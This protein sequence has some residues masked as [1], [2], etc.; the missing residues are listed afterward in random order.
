MLREK[1]V[2]LMRNVNV[3]ICPVR[4]FGS[5]AQAIF[6]SGVVITRDVQSQMQGK[7]LR[8]AHKIKKQHEIQVN[9]KPE[10]IRMNFIRNLSPTNGTTFSS[11]S[12]GGTTTKTKPIC[13]LLSTEPALSPNNEVA[14]FGLG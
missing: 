7:Q 4:V 13:P 8:K 5:P 9:Q 2:F 10:D 6:A 1:I 11:S 3:T 12:G 14:I